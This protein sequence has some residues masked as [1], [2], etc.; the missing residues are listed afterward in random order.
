M[1]I[2]KFIKEEIEKVLDKQGLENK[3]NQDIVY[4]KGFSLNNKKDNVGN[5]I[6]IF[7]HKEKDY[8]LRFYI[9]NNKNDDSWNTKIFIYWKEPSK[10]FTNARGKDF[11]HTFGP[12]SSYDEMVTE[13][14]RKLAN[15]PLISSKN[16]SDNDNVQFNK[17]I[18]EMMK[19]LLEYDKQL[20][21]VRDSYFN[22][23]KKTYN[24]VKSI[25]TI[26]ELQDYI[27]KKYP[28]DYDKQELLL[29]LQKIYKLDFY[30]KK[31]KLEDLF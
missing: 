10:N 15:N 4:L 23:L 5:T 31:E 26:V 20:E 2:R 27:D 19:A 17:D 7:G 22:D 9:Q 21:L 8:T 16:Y 14:N 24:K 12:F 30:L 6:W 13:L 1:D 25:K 11:E 18:I 3:F 29:I 28:D